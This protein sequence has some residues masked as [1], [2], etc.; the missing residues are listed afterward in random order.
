DTSDPYNYL[1][2]ERGAD[3]DYA[4]LG[5]K[6]HKTGQV[7]DTE[8]PFREL[9]ELF[10]ELVPQA[11]IDHRWSG[12]VIETNDGLPFIGPTSEDQFVATGY[13]GNGMT[14]GTLGG[15]MATDFIT[16]RKNP[17]QDLFDVNRKKLLGGTWEYLKE[18]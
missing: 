12:Q 9:Q 5:G 1:R 14:F 13:A 18:N 11:Q 15:M 6:D 8:K 2:I 16:G 3:H 4:I 17:W 7:E 10:L